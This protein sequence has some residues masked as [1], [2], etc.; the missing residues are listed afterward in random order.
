MVPKTVVDQCINNEDAAKVNGKREYLTILFSD[1]RGF[2][3]MSEALTPEEV[4]EILNEYMG[5][6]T[7]IIFRNKGTLD[8]F[9]GDAI[10]VIFGAPIP[11]EDHPYYAVKCAVE[12]RDKLNELRRKWCAEGKRM[13][14]VGIG[15]NTGDV[16]VGN[17]G[18]EHRMNYTVI[19][20]H[21]NLAAR[22]E[23]NTK[24]G[25][26]L[27][28]GD[29][30]KHVKDQVIYEKPDPIRVKGKSMLI[31]IYDIL[32]IKEKEMGEAKEVDRE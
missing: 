18:S 11:F 22:L 12:M 26:I 14:N 23:A 19:G 24:G 4:V 15:I 32:G 9:I 25:Q 27:I 8:K 2:T 1:I 6:M 29:T 31:P 10:M 13:I 20:D 16:V 5:E 17:M 28:S 21:V 3:P 7:K 30:F